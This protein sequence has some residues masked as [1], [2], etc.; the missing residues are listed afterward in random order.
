MPRYQ[1]LKFWKFFAKNSSFFGNA[2]LHPISDL[3]LKI[4]TFFAFMVFF[5][6]VATPE[7][8]ANRPRNGGFRGW[9]LKAKK[10]G[11]LLFLALGDLWDEGQHGQK[12]KKF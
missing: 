7:T 5:F 6:W 10:G 9:A 11:M 8:I 4:T 12:M 1:R 3:A 2:S